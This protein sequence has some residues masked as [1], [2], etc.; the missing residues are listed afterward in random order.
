MQRRDWI[1]I[2]KFLFIV[3]ILIIFLYA[4]VPMGLKLVFPFYHQE[5]I[6]FYATKHDIDPLLVASIIWVESR[7]DARAESPRGAR[8]LMQIMPE[9]GEWISEQINVPYDLQRLYDPNHNI[10]LG[11][12]YLANLRHEFGGNMNL[13]LAAY[14]GGRGN[15]R[16]WMDAGIWQ[17]DKENID[18]IPFGETREYV[19]RVNMIY[20][21]YQKLYG[22]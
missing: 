8:G 22:N 17:G 16:S 19:R 13:V 9:T 2:K 1:D 10:R 14:N 20:Q 18:D 3:I 11:C 5:A 21:V 6:E 15:V 7:F 12:W 4:V